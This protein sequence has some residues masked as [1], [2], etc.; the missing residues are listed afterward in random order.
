LVRIVGMLHR[1]LLPRLRA[2]FRF[3]PFR[4]PLKFM[5]R[6]GVEVNV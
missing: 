5:F 2:K 6:H 4:L 1:P 3:T